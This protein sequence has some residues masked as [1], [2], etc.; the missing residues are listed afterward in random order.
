MTRRNILRVFY[1]AVLIIALAGQA[2]AAR[3]WLGWPLLAAV[4]AVA[5]VEFGG[6]VLSAHA[7]ERRRLG[8]RALP[9]RLLA[10][11]VA[12]GAVA[13]NWL[14]HADHLV[15]G[16]F[17]GM[18][19][20]GF[21]I[22]IIDSAARRRDALRAAGKLPPTPP[23]FGVV[24]WLRH[25][26]LTRRARQ[27]ALKD[28]SLGL[29]GSLSAATAAVRSERRRAAIAAELRTMIAAAAGP[30]MATVA[31]N[32][33]DMDEI[34]HRLAATADYDGLAERLAAQLTPAALAPAVTGELSQPGTVELSEAGQ[35]DRGESSSREVSGV[36][37]PAHGTD[38]PGAETADVNGSAQVSQTGHLAGDLFDLAEL[39][40]APPIPYPLPKVRAEQVR[41]SANGHAG[42]L[43]AVTVTV[44]DR[45]EPDGGDGHRDRQND[46]HEDTEMTGTATAETAPDDGHDDRPRDGQNEATVPANP[47]VTPRSDDG[48]EGG[49]DDRQNGDTAPAKATGSSSGRRAAN[50]RRVAQALKRTPDAPAAEIARRTRVSERTVRRIRAKLRDQADSPEGLAS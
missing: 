4:A 11:A 44:T 20:L 33:F 3:D 23:V 39:V 13:L 14:G 25:P 45:P 18:S 37:H 17:A 24:Q 22:W 8:E 41:A 2:L 1:A 46:G 34:A 38:E 30:T 28:P 29:Y 21:S 27:L 36:G 26:W 43:P 12:A 10:A 42:R 47:T 35:L 15:G 31:V 32:T 5:G 16:F 9:A 49:H 40:T 7:D 19:G 6:V 48:H 50:E